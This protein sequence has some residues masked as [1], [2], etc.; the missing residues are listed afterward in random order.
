MIHVS[1]M[2]GHT[3]AYELAIGTT[4]LINGLFYILIL[5]ISTVK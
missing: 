1:N 2:Q 5:Q 4:L 3:M